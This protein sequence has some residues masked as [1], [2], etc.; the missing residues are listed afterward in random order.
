MR[1][2]CPLCT[3][4]FWTRP[5]LRSHLR[6]DHTPVRIKR[7]RNQPPTTYEPSP[8]LSAAA[9]TALAEADAQALIESRHPVPDYSGPT[10]GES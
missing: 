5:A 8:V 1:A 6:A 10:D 2:K 3:R 7:T 4:K 9:A